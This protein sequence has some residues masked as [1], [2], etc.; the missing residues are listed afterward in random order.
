[1]KLPTG[2]RLATASQPAN[3]I[4]PDASGVASGMAD[5]ADL[6]SG[7]PSRQGRR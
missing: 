4:G 2:G 3:S 6:T 5:R 7:H 1:V